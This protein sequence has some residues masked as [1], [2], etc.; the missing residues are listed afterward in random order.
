MRQKS[1]ELSLI[2]GVSVPFLALS[3]KA[4]FPGD[5][6]RSV[7]FEQIRKS[8]NKDIV[9]GLSFVPQSPPPC[10]SGPPSIAG[11]CGWI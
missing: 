5:E 1:S 10:R 7:Y 4:G 6:V 3:T 9:E 11:G 8:R 2:E